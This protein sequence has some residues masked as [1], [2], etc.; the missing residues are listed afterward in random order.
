MNFDHA[1]QTITKRGFTERQARFLILVARHSGVCVMRQY[2]TFAGIVFGQKTRKFF[3]NL[4]RAKL[5]S[6]YDCAHNRARVFH[7]RHRSIYYAIGEPDSGLRRPP[8][9]PRALERLMLLDAI[10]AHPESIWL[11]SSAEKVEHFSS[12][13]V[14]LD[15]MPRLVIGQGDQR[16]FRYFPDRLPIGVVPSGPAVFIYMAADPMRDDFREFLQRHAALLERLPSWTVRIVVPAYREAVVPELQKAAWSQLASPLREPI[17]TELRW[18]FSR[19]TDPPTAASP[20]LERARFERCRRAFSTDRYTVLYRRLKQDGERVLTLASSQVLADA[21]EGGAGK[22]EPLVLPHAYS[23]LAP[24]A[25]V[26]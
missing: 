24:L 19:L 26:A 3:A 7:L 17:L 5:V 16:R 11:S 20:T 18:Y 13:G 6:T 21:I 1:V 22:F 8:S 4:L 14:P 10:L 15:D 9:V 12:R 23:H 2:S 25:G